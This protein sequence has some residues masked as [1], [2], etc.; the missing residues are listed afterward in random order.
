MTD[1]P[2]DA[3][4]LDLEAVLGHFGLE[5]FNLLGAVEAGQMAITY[6]VRHRARVARLVL[7][8]AWPKGSD[9]RSSR[10]DTW[11]GF[12]DQDWELM[13]DT[14]VQIALGWSGSDVGRSATERNA[15]DAI[16]G[17]LDLSLNGEW[18]HRFY[19]DGASLRNWCAWD[20]LFIAPL[21]K[22]TVTIESDSPETKEKVR[23]AV[24]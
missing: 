1:F 5:R 14:C 21:L 16:I 15:N 9:I 6:A 7:W 22:Q 11:R 23:V 3:L 8:C 13:T 24:G 12:I 20:S 19:V 17:V 18:V 10:M 2:L 4:V